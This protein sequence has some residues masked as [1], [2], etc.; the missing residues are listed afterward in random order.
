MRRQSRLFH[1]RPAQ[2]S[3]EGKFN[4]RRFFQSPSQYRDG[5]ASSDK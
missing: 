4:W 3:H 5:D 1:A 2:I